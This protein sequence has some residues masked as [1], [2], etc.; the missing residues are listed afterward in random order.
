MNKKIC[1]KCMG[2]KKNMLRHIFHFM[3]DAGSCYCRGD[4]KKVK[5]FKITDFEKIDCPYKLEHIVI[6]QEI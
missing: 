3:W 2:G 5:I 1:E 4:L 6:S